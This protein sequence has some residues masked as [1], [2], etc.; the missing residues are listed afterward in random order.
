LG[1]NEGQ[2][3]MILSWGEDKKMILWDLETASLIRTY[4]VQQGAKAVFLSE[5]KKQV[6]TYGREKSIILHD[7]DND[8]AKAQ[9]VFTGHTGNVKGVMV[10]QDNKLLSWGQDK[11]LIYWNMNDH[12]NES[13]HQ[14]MEGHS[15]EIEGVL[16]LPDQTRVLTWSNTES[17]CLW[18]L[19]THKIH[20]TEFKIHTKYGNSKPQIVGVQLFNEGKNAISWAMDKTVAIYDLHNTEKN[21]HFTGHTKAVLPNGLFV[22]DHGKKILSAS[23]H[24]VILWN[25]ADGYI[26][27]N[28]KFYYDQLPVSYF[29]PVIHNQE[30][31]KFIVATTTGG[32]AAF[33]V[34]PSPAPPPPK[35]GHTKK[36]SLGK[37]P[38]K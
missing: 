22:L 30:V 29:I 28:I 36:G 37:E 4:T 1:E 18:N 13:N 33:K 8:D 27:W 19:H 20:P 21:V 35:K 14:I 2:K 26:F 15:T 34:N 11:K 23:S 7:L 38:T 17:I 9:I 25:A 12:K 10:F 32:V 3:K 5:S 24:E 6:I 16:A 31:V